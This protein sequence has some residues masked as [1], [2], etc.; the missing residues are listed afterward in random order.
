M[1]LLR[2]VL[3]SRPVNAL[4]RAAAWPF[5]DAIPPSWQFPVNGVVHID[6]PGAGAVRLRVNPT[7]FQGKQFY[8]HGISGFEPAV[9]R[10]FRELVSASSGFLDIGA[11]L[12]LYSLLARAYR[13]GI[14]VFAFEP[15]PAAYSFLQQNLALNGMADIDA[16]PVALSDENGSATFHAPFNSK[17]AYLKAHLGGTGSL[18]AAASAVNRHAVT[19]PT[20]R[21]DDFLA[22]YEG[23][24][25][26]LIKLDTEGTEDRVM[27][28]AMQTLETH[29]P[30]ILCEV[31]QGRIEAQLDAKLTTLDYAAYALT[32]QGPRPVTD[33]RTGRMDTNDYL[34]CPSERAGDIAQ[35]Q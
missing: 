14:R 18:D 20:A 31:L 32:A 16:F 3:Y 24:P 27:E 12:G 6:L 11:N 30:M 19:V 17:F 5:R 22:G 29:R 28:G 13:P 23:S 10:V 21:L 8:W 1:S 4:L 35:L 2:P 26:D 15:L 9:H 34:F 33:L 7:S 25:V